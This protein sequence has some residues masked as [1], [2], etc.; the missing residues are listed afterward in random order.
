MTKCAKCGKDVENKA[1]EI[2]NGEIHCL[3]CARKK[4]RK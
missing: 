1:V 4:K 2:I 3:S